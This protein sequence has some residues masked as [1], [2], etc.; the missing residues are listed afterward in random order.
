MEVFMSERKTPPAGL[1]R[2][3][4]V[5]RSRA[6][7][8]SL[9][10]LRRLQTQTERDFDGLAAKATRD[11]IRPNQP[12]S[13][14]ED[15]TGNYEGEELARMRATKR[16]PD[17]RFELLDRH[18][19]ETKVELQGIKLDVSNLRGD[20]STLK[21]TVGE[22]KG[23]MEVWPRIH[24]QLD[25]LLK[26]D[27]VKLEAKID[28]E[29]QKT[30]A[31]IEERRADRAARRKLWGEIIAKIMLGVAAIWAVIATILLAKYGIGG[32]GK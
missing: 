30:A 5:E 4:F 9:G 20:I 15:I 19:D 11:A 28:I 32:A 7:D 22:I 23:Q 8:D 6:Q 17:E 12:E 27:H 29:R 14:N 21:G 31:E 16:S 13:W 2:R 18:R 1:P 24:D 25:T 3:D 10:K 26:R